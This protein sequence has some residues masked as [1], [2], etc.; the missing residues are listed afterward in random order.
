MTTPPSCT[1]VRQR[2]RQRPRHAKKL[3]QSIILSLTIPSLRRKLSGLHHDVREAKP[4]QLLK[5]TWKTSEMLWPPYLMSMTRSRIPRWSRVGLR[6]GTLAGAKPALPVLLH[7]QIAV[8]RQA[9]QRRK[10]ELGRRVI[11]VMRLLSE[12]PPQGKSGRSDSYF[13]C[14]CWMSRYYVDKRILCS[15]R[16]SRIARRQNAPARRAEWAPE[17][18]P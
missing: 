9:G 7:R 15:Y 16:Q 17:S 12:A 3:F 5:M 6:R 13:I 8:E 11:P 14:I 18:D 1:Q 10:N 2:Q 4:R